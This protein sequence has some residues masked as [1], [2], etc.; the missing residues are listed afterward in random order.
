MDSPELYSK[1]NGQV[2]VNRMV[3]SKYWNLIRWGKDSESVFEAGIGD[4][5]VTKEVLIPLLPDNI[6][7]YVASDVSNRMVDFANTVIDNSK[8]KF[9]QLDICDDVPLEY[10][11]RFHKIFA[12]FLLHMLSSN[13]K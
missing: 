1:A 3:L 13:L 9:I 6:K 4:G 7:E 5:Q 8:F 11:N 2:T 12:C 10:H